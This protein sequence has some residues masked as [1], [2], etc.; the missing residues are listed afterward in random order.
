[1]YDDERDKQYNLQTML[2][3]M[4]DKADG[5]SF[6]LAITPIRIILQCCADLGNT[7]S[8][9]ILASEDNQQIRNEIYEDFMQW[10][11]GAKS[12]NVKETM[13]SFIRF[14]KKLDKIIPWNLDPLPS[15][16]NAEVFVD[17]VSKELHRLLIEK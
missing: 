11:E 2:R 7:T 6:A 15:N 1:M 14:R 8:I 9:T 10:K 16:F 4:R 13:T 5:E 17:Y 3:N 12:E